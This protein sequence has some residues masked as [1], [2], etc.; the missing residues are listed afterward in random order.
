MPPWAT[1]VTSSSTSLPCIFTHPSRLPQSR[2]PPERTCA[3]TSPQPRRPGSPPCARRAS[4]RRA[5][6]A[7]RRGCRGRRRT[8]RST[9][10]RW[11]SCSPGSRPRRSLATTR[12]WRADRRLHPRRRLGLRARRRHLRQAAPARGRPRALAAAARAHRAPALSGHWLID[13]RG[14]T[15]GE[16]AGRG[17]HLRG[18]VRRRHHRRRDRRLHRHRRAARGRRRV[19]HRQPRRAVHRARST[20]D[21]HAVVG[22]SLAAAARLL[23][24]LGVSWPSLWNRG[25]L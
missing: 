21:P 14:G 2:L 6:V 5:P 18:D 15:L 20:G 11:C 3:C 22:L 23:L 16:R 13:H 25:A 4:N 8:A 7:G 12:R 19:H 10:P 1:L 24:E 17:V 9:P